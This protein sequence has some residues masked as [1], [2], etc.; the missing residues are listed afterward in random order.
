MWIDRRFHVPYTCAALA[1]N[2]SRARSIAA[3]LERA[4]PAEILGQLNAQHVSAMVVATVL[5]DVVCT[6]GAP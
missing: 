3:V 6:H 4:S 2:C 5:T 1:H